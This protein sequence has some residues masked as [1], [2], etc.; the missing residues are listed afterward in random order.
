[1]PIGN[2]LKLSYW[3]NMRIEHH[4]IEHRESKKCVEKSKRNYTLPNE[5]QKW[6]RVLFANPH[7]NCRTNTTALT[8]PEIF[9]ANRLPEVNEIRTQ[10]PEKKTCVPT[11]NSRETPLNVDAFSLNAATSLATV[12]TVLQR[13][14]SETERKV[15]AR[16]DAFRLPWRM[17][18]EGKWRM[19]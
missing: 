18:E 2:E 9:S 1:M 4:R 10:D 13:S 8:R 11:R 16:G 17:E 3:K 12:I 6:T 15:W 19:R 14:G 7:C 5:H